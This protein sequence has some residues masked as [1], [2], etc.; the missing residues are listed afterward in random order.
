MRDNRPLRSPLSPQ[1][2]RRAEGADFRLPLGLGPTVSGLHEIRLQTVLRVLAESGA[3]SVLDLG[4][5]A[6]AL[7]TRLVHCPCFEV[8]VGL[9]S[10]SISLLHAREALGDYLEGSPARLRLVQ[11]S[12]TDRRP[13]LLGFDACS[14]VE[15]IEHVEPGRLSEV[16][17]V[18]FGYFRPQTVVMTTPNGDFNPL[19]GLPPGKFR[20]P[21]HQFEWD[22]AKFQ[23][24]VSGV[25]V[26]K[27]YAV[28]FDGIGNAHPTLGPPTQMAVFRRQV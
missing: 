24:W 5:G 21:H 2:N 10:S 12:Y 25:A 6:G 3:R 28:Q 4:C 18:V 22:R 23:A 11:A 13:D 20:H 1:G 9:D 26:R 15:T 17:D 8:I 7:L 14:L 27:Q 19:L 16:E